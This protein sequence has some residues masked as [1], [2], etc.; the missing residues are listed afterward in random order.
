MLLAVAAA[1]Q[2]AE[3]PAAAT[4]AVREVHTKVRGSAG[5]GAPPERTVYRF[6]LGCPGGYPAELKED[7][8][9]AAVG[10]RIRVAY[11]PA[12]RVS[13]SWRA[14]PPRGRPPR[15]PQP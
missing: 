14:R 7:R 1:D 8:A 13:P 10:A 3:R 9:V 5:D 6:V 12:H 4:C 15:G 11:D 2:A